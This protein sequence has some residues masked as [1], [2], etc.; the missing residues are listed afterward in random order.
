MITFEGG[1]PNVGDDCN[2]GAGNYLAIENIGGKIY[3]TRYL[4]LNSAPVVSREDIV[5]QGQVIRYVG[6]SNRSRARH[7]HFEIRLGSEYGRAIAPSNVGLN[8]GPAEEG[9]T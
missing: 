3:V 4:H 2:R 9:R 6:N 5:K 8:L 1:C 7:A